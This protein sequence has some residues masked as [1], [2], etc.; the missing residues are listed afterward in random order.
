M[1]FDKGS[2]GMETEELP[3]YREQTRQVPVPVPPPIVPRPT[4]AVEGIA[5]VT[6]STKV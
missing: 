5:T 3:T 6:D 1:C 2:I 4:Q